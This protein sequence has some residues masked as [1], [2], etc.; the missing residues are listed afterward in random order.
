MAVHEAIRSRDSVRHGNDGNFPSLSVESSACAH[1]KRVL[2][3]T[4]GI[5]SRLTRHVIPIRC[6]RGSTE[7]SESPGWPPKWSNSNSLAVR[8]LPPD[9]ERSN[10][11]D[12]KHDDEKRD[13]F[14]RRPA[15]AES[16]VHVDS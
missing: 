2:K 14:G 5:A 1:R 15:A 13:L 12:C 3:R 9:D 16:D 4:A 10:C 8:E 7:A 6:D 11:W